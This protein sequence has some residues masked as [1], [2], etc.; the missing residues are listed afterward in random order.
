MNRGRKKE[1]KY[2]TKKKTNGQIQEKSVTRTNQER[3]YQIMKQT[4]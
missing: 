2:E 1:R 4:K 3:K